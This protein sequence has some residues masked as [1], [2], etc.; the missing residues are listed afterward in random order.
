[1]R[2][3]TLTAWAGALTLSLVTG[4][5]QGDGTGASSDTVTYWLWDANQLPAYQACAKGFEQENPGLDVRI[6]Q[7]GWSDYWTKLTA[8][9]IAGTQPDVFTDHI[10][11]FGQFADL[12]VLEPLDDL[13][14]EESDYQ[15][16]LAANWI[17]RD[18]H[19]YGTP[20]DWDTVALFY[21]K[22]MVKDAGLTADELNGLSWN[23]QDG[24][25]F[26]KAVAHLTVDG[27]G[28]RGDEPGFDKDDVK[29]YGLASNGGGYADGQTQWS[30]FT[31][32][33]G[34]SYTDKARWGTKYQYDSETFQS[35]IKWYFG[36]A[37]KGYMVPF[38]DYNVQSNQANT[39]IA[40]G[41]AAVTFDGAWMISTYDGFK[42]LD[43]GAAV[44]PAG[45]SGR[46]ATMMNGLADSIT[47]AS[48]NKAGARK[49]V[50]YLASDACQ[51]VV[52]EYGVVFPATPAGTE[53]AVAAYEKKGLDVSAFTEPVADKKDFRTFSYP[54]TTYAADVTALMQPAMED[55]YGNGAPVSGLDE[56][57]D[58]INLILDQ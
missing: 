43:I 47:K 9:F 51:S 12:Q 48:A 46:R 27:K 36:L 45:P 30:P 4:C 7:L 35:V 44:T 24:G 15:P 5:T 28:R 56:T 29:V 14:I 57:N 21:N 40:A 3:R 19:R 2:L 26:E 16:G 55:I 39:Q 58:Q 49:W 22:A 18:G 17:G 41:R 31:G 20:K 10:Q 37:E 50:A 38:A 32:S 34:W 53:A 11:K 8:G 6:T 52:G 42:D 33:A 54:I 23:P 25:T 13:G 1:M